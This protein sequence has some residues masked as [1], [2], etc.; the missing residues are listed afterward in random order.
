MAVEIDDFAI[1]DVERVILARV[2]ALPDP[3]AVTS[4]VNRYLDGL[5]NCERTN[6]VAVESYIKSATSKLEAKF[7]L[8]RHSE[9]C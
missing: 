9:G 3:H 4:G 6:H 7:N 8:V 5:V 2:P 1:G